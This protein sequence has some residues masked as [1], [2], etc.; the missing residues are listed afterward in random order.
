MGT[1]TNAVW[2]QL[3]APTA[4]AAVIRWGDSNTSATRG[5]II[6]AGGGQMLPPVPSRITGYDLT[7]LYYYCT[8]SDKLEIVYA[9]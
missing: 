9:R 8:A 3:V 1:A 2:V 5:A 6:A 7:K 4:N